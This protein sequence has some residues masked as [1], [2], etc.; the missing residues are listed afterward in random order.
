MK[1]TALAIPFCLWLFFSFPVYSQKIVNL[2]RETKSFDITPYM[3]FYEEKDGNLT[4]Q[5]VLKQDAQGR[6]FVQKNTANFGTTN[7]KIW[8]KFQ[9]NNESSSDWWVL[10][11]HSERL[12]GEMNIY[13]VSDNKVITSFHSNDWKSFHTRL[14]QHRNLIYP[15]GNPGKIQTIYLNIKPSTSTIELNASL[16]TALSFIEKDYGDMLILG[17]YYGIMFSM[18]IYN[19]FIL[20]ATRDRAYFYYIIYLLVYTLAQSTLDGLFFQYMSPDNLEAWQSIIIFG[21]A[22][23]WPC[24]ILFTTSLLQI[25]KHYPR[26]YIFYQIMIFMFFIPSLTYSFIGFENSVKFVGL[27]III[28]TISS[29]LVSLLLSF[30]KNTIAR[31]Y[32]IATFIFI[33]GMIVQELKI[34]NIYIPVL[35][36][37]NHSIQLGSA[38][39]ALLFSLALGY[40]IKLMRQSIIEKDNELLNAKY[41]NLKDK[42]NPHFVLNTLSIIMSYL[43]KDVNKANAALNYFTSAYKYLIRHENTHLTSIQNEINFTRDYGNILL[44]KF[45][46][47]L[48]INYDISGELDGVMIPFLSLQPVV[49]NAFKHGIRKI[50][51][52]IIDIKIKVSGEK[53]EI[54]IRN[55]SNGQPIKNPFGGT[56]GAI[57][58]RIEYFFEDSGLTISV[59][60]KETIV[61][62]HYKN[63]F[64]NHPAPN[65]MEKIN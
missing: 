41:T 51:N 55:S 62:I 25:K 17:I 14:V 57:K 5:D 27:L 20:F 3:A 22:I 40:K 13:V 34:F 12:A 61:K 15:L 35:S 56:L 53:V 49:E 42:M 65:L 11:F 38:L 23:A 39:E 1:K 44:I 8:A 19:I 30:N 28:I 7:M 48:K 58:R 64:L 4:I 18:I 59:H 26:W 24:S 63:R 21:A 50:G 29:F 45:S 33:L 32:F 10:C 16:Y 43:K 31:Y 36:Q 47:T 9:L 37:K 6:L 54:E 52:G 60:G 2:T 46:D